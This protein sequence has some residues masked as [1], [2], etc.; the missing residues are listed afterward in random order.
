MYAVKNLVIIKLT[1]LKGLFFRRK[2]MTNLDSILKNR[3]STVLIKVGM[4]KCYGFSSS[5]VWM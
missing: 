2:S 1:K 3:D 5:H 4:A